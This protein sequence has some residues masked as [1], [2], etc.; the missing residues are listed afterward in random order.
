MKKDEGDLSF[1][2]LDPRVPRVPGGF[3]DEGFL[4]PATTY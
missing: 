1:C 4:E 3:F 2:S